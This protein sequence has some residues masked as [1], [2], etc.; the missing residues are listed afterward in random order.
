MAA[1]LFLEM[2]GRSFQAPG[3]EAVERTL[4]L[5]AGAITETDYADWLKWE[6]DIFPGNLPT[7]FFPLSRPALFKTWGSS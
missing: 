3:I 4:A 5:A 2:N 6:P 7:Y 1:A